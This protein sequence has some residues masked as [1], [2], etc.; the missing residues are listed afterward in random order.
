MCWI[1]RPQALVGGIVSIT[2]I[3]IVPFLS[4]S[5]CVLS[6]FS[7]S[8]VCLRKSSA[9]KIEESRRGLVPGKYFSTTGSTFELTRENSKMI[10]EG[11][12]SLSNLD[13][14]GN[15]EESRKGMLVITT[16]IL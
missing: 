14:R 7:S 5:L 12:W 1:C 16:D 2:Q 10:G 6:L 11:I 15:L 8:L 13:C 4:F 9:I 3:F